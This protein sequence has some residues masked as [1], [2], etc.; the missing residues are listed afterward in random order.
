MTMGT[1][2]AVIAGIQDVVGAVSGIT[3]APDIPPEQLPS[4]GVYALLYPA[5]GTYRFTTADGQEDGQHTLH[6]MIAT[7]RVNLRTDWARIIDIGDAVQLALLSSGTLSGAITQFDELRYTFGELEWGGQ[8]LF[9][10]RFE[11]DVRLYGA[12]S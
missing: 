10:W 8:Q 11:L 5:A 7:P 2:A 4:G 12:L 6:L 3:L 9:G 1:L